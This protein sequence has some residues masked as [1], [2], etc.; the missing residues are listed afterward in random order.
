M[1]HF[2][3][4]FSNDASNSPFAIEL[5][6]LGVPHRLFAAKLTFRYHSRVWLALVGWPKL[7]AF[8]TRS[9]VRSLVRS[10]PRPT[11]A[12]VG[13]HLEVLAFSLLQALGFSRSTRLVL[14]GFIFT[15]RSSNL[16]NALRRAYFRFVFRYADLAICHSS[17][18][19]TQYQAVF[20]GCRTRFVYMPYGMHVAGT[21]ES[22][23]T[24]K[25]DNARPYILSAGR[26]GRDYGTLLAAVDGL[27]IDVH[28]VCDR[29]APLAGLTVPK[30]VTVLKDCYDSDYIEQLRD[31]LFVVV[32][33]SVHDISAGQMV[34]L[35]AMAFE[36]ASII[37]K[38]ETIE[39]YVRDG[40]ESL[41]V[42]QGNAVAL[43]DAIL[44]L[45]ENRPL[46]AHLAANG[47]Q[48]FE[49]RFSMAAYVRQLV[50]AV[51]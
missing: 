31:C 39:E 13:S 50:A 16:V 47:R 51:G 24:A 46:M 5:R 6:R 37:T 29:D 19:A 32:P 25:S 9:A 1:L 40:V 2:F 28:I 38:T 27:D 4:T 7:A 30:S 34:L 8:A 18:E 48:A 36:K 21:G 42:E 35:Q 22:R 43:R 33:L 12:I 3:P 45:M 17:L 44:R 20:K 41:L 49:Q 11:A 26:S 10:R 23:R 14:L 15:Q